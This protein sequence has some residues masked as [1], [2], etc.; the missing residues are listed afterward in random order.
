MTLALIAANIAVFFFIQP[1]NDAAEEERFVY[2]YAAIACEL[3]TGDPLSGEEIT[4]GDCV[5]T[6]AA[7]VFPDKNVYLAVVVS[8]FLHAGF[9]HLLGNMWFLW[10][11]GNNVEEA[12]GR[13]GFLLLYF[14]AGVVATLGFVLLNRE[15]TDPLIGASGAVAGV[16][17]AYLVLFPTHRVLSWFL[18]IIVAV[19]S[20]FFLLFW[21]IAQ[22]ALI[23]ADSGVAWEAHVFGFGFG[24]LV[25]LPLRETMLR[26]V[27]RGRAPSP[28]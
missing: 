6:A 25:A 13:I 21:F 5:E 26:R 17:G 10:I 18:F 8:M 23:G 2:E 14:G 19:P 24:A 28:F 1:L 15:I 3:T 22:F 9:G 12:F 20:V 4:S 7:P 16:M 11:F 27:S